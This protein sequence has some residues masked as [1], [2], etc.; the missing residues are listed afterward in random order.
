[1][2]APLTDRQRRFL[3]ARRVGHL[4]TAGTDGQPHV[5]PVCFAVFG[6]TLYVT[7]DAKPKQTG[8][9]LRRI[10]NILANP[11]ACFVADRYDEDWSRLAWV[12]LRG[13][14][15]SL[16]CGAEHDTAQALL[17]AR[18]PQLRA[19]NIEH[20]PVIAVR[21]ARVTSWGK[22]EGDHTA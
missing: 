3:Q 6:A 12:M 2:A 17:R 8:G 4:A 11:A 15:D 14:A 18:Y 21:V 19:M 5:V 9:P 20:H 1:M 10:A 16:A 22:L 7:I 13:H